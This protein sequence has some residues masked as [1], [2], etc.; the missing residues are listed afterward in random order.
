MS[1]SSATR[2]WGEYMRINGH[3]INLQF[4]CPVY[5]GMDVTKLHM[6]LSNQSKLKLH[7]VQ[8]EKKISYYNSNGEPLLYIE[9]TNDAICRIR[10]S[11]LTQLI[12]ERM[13]YRVG[14]KIFLTDTRI[15]GYM[16]AIKGN[17][18]LYLKEDKNV[19]ANDITSASLGVTVVRRTKKSAQS[20]IKA[21]NNVERN[22]KNVYNI[23]MYKQDTEVIKQLERQY[24]DLH[25]KV[26][27]TQSRLKSIRDTVEQ[28]DNIRN[29]QEEAKLKAKNCNDAYTNE[30][31]K[32][33]NVDKL[34][35]LGKLYYDKEKLCLNTGSDKSTRVCKTREVPVYES[36]YETV[37]P[38]I[39][40]H[41]DYEQYEGRARRESYRICT[42]KRLTGYKTETYYEDNVDND[43]KEASSIVKHL[44][45]YWER[46]ISAVQSLN[47]IEIEQQKIKQTE[48]YKSNVTMITKL[49]SELNK[50][51]AQEQVIKA[52]LYGNA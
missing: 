13:Y 23:D 12:P 7:P 25:S 11:G 50:L 44:D 45:E 42:G 31:S 48:D 20:I 46:Y 35:K 30:I 4:L 32:A 52:Q 9:S 51:R 18:E 40:C 39:L 5:M 47:S 21:Y 14:K 28:T 3:V 8:D 43:F 41:E 16:C 37:S 38:D 49:N 34:I 29:R 19:Q 6:H 1:L 22:T 10:Y 17:D 26:I 36:V 33:R 27:E 24:K 15:D 2:G